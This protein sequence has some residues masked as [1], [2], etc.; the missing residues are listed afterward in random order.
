MER[1]ITK[2]LYAKMN[3]ALGSAR[4]TLTRHLDAELFG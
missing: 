1:M 2:S 4:R 3:E